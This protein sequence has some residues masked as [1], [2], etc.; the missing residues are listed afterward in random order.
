M[1]IERLDAQAKITLDSHD[2]A[3]EADSIETDV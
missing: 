1:S 3:R 2:V